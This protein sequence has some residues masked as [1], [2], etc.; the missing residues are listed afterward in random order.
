MKKR[1]VITDLSRMR[2]NRVCIFGVDENGKGVR[3]DVPYSG[4][5]ENDLMN[6]KG[7]LIIKPFAEIEFDFIRPLP[8]PPHIEDWELNTNYRPRL[9]RNLSKGESESFLEKILDRSV[10]DIFGAVIHNNQYINEGEG[11]KSLGTVK[12][13]EVLSV[14]YSLK[15]GERYDYRIKF[16]DATVEIYDLPVTDLA[17]RGYCDERRVQGQGTGAISAKLQYR[18]RQSHVFLRVG[19]ARPFAKMYNRCYLQVSG[20]HTFPNYRQGN[21]NERMVTCGLPSEQD[22]N[23]LGD[24]DYKNTVSTLLNDFDSRNRA[25]AAYLL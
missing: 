25:K 11:N 2:G 8:K 1:L 14:R 18:L 20:I 19:L 24:I 22:R 5:R 23:A 12:A 10:K 6:E 7:Q 17:F 9:I 3:P 4:I 21:I 16:S 13:K 15:E